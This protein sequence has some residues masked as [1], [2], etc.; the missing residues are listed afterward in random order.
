MII[1][2]FFEEIINNVQHLKDI[3]CIEILDN[4]EYKAILSNTEEINKLKYK[5]KESSSSKK[6]I[7]QISEVIVKDP[8]QKE[9]IEI[10]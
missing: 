1:D 4:G 9:I 5:K 6:Q 10:D 3:E 2:T 8:Y 7:K